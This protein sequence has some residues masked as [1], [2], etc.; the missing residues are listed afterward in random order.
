MEHDHL[1]QVMQR[2]HKV[3]RARLRAQRVAAARFWGEVTISLILA[4]AGLIV[5]FLDR[6]RAHPHAAWGIPVFTWLLVAAVILPMLALVSLL[7]RVG[8]YLLEKALSRVYENVQYVLISLRRGLTCAPEPACS[9]SPGLCWGILPVNWDTTA[10]PERNVHDRRAC[11]CAQR[12][13]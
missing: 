5:W 12:A 3:H 13:A 1:K 4:V 7:V 8:T 9:R 2:S 11:P 6:H 10:S